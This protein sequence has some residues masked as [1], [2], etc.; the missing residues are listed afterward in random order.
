MILLLLCLQILPERE[1]FIY[2]TND[3]VKIDK[4]EVRLSIPEQ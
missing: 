1:F 4:I 2:K 3:L